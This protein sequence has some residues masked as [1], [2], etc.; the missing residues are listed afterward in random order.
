MIKESF[1]KNERI[2]EL[3]IDIAI[4]LI[5]IL[6]FRWSIGDIYALF[7]LELLALGVFTILK[8][9]IAKSDNARFVSKAFKVIS[10][11]AMFTI[12]LLLIIIITGF[13]FNGIEAQMK[14]SI[15]KNT[16]YLLLFNQLLNFF[17]YIFRKRYQSDSTNYLINQ[18][19]KRLGLLI[20]V[21]FI[22][23][24]PFMGWL[25]SKN[26][27]YILGSVL[28]IGK[29]LSDYWLVGMLGNSIKKK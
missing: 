7:F 17:Y 24:L 4:P 18:C 11:L 8:I 10:F 19:F 28:I 21:L 12:A 22:L 13:F 1:I 23:F 3:I 20:L 25:G 5:G 27:N 26:E 29:R 15:G 6:F 14:L 9:F 2:V 16:I